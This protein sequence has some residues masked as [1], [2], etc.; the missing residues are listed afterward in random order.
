ML[1]NVYEVCSCKAETECERKEFHSPEIRYCGDKVTHQTIPIFNVNRS[2]DYAL[3]DVFKFQG[4][5]IHI[6]DS[7][8]EEESKGSEFN[9][10]NEPKSIWEQ[11]K[12]NFDPLSWI[13]S[14]IGYIALVI[15]V[16]AYMKR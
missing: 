3:D 15:S 11:M 2:I 6:I 16:L 14:S 12:S 5:D 10:V 13:S 9:D 8:A 4:K 7:I 1:N